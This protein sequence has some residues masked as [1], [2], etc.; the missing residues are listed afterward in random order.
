LKEPAAGAVSVAARPNARLPANVTLRISLL[1]EI[2][3]PLSM[4]SARVIAFVRTLSA[5]SEILDKA[6]AHC[7]AKK[8]DPSVLL[9]AR[10]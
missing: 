10:L 8:I 4:Y 6:A 2:A 9:T 3:M 5:L 1:Q 7:A